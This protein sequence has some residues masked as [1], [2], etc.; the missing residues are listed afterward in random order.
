MPDKR[1]IV[2]FVAGSGDTPE[3]AVADAK[4]NFALSTFHVV[5]RGFLNPSDPHSYEEKVNIDGHPRIVIMG[6]TLERGETTN[7]M[8]DMLPMR[9]KIR[10]A[11]TSLP[12]SPR[13]HWIKIVYA[14]N[15]SKTMLCAVTVDNEDS[16]ALQ[17]AINKLPWPSQEKFYM[18]KQFI[19]VK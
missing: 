8:P 1:E 3:K 13:P 5:Y 18:A 14:N 19:L 10:E 4:M 11:L 12:L 17:E 16:P 9:A 7:N 6:D 15:K 2:D